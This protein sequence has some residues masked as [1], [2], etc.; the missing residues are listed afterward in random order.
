MVHGLLGSGRFDFTATNNRVQTTAIKRDGKQTEQ[1]K[2]DYES[3]K[4]V[5]SF[6]PSWR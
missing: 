1:N 3:F 5:L 2:K 4:R 6:I